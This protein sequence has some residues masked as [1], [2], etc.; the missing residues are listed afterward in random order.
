MYRFSINEVK[1]NTGLNEDF[2]AALALAKND[3]ELIHPIVVD[4]ELNYRQLAFY[5]VDCDVVNCDQKK[6]DNITLLTMDTP[7]NIVWTKP[8]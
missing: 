8:E 7:L 4:Y 5:I 1:F 3:Y 6:I 2:A